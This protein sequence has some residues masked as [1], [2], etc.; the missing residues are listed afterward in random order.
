MAM[1]TLK[2]YAE[3]HGR[4]PATFRQKALR[5]GFKTAQKIGRDWMIDENEPLQDKRVK[6]GKYI[7]FRDN[8]N[9]E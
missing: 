7:G 4:D 6:T 3:R 9:K 8:L 1:I 5:G 2:E